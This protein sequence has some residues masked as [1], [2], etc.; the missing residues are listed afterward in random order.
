MSRTPGGGVSRR[1]VLVGGPPVS[2]RG[3]QGPRPETSAEAA[4]SPGPSPARLDPDRGL[5]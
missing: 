2:P 1:P 4:V 5:E 3:R